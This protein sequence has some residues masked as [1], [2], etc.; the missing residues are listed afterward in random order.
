MTFA[1][2]AIAGGWSQ[3]SHRVRAAA[4]SAIWIGSQVAVHPRLQTAHHLL[5]TGR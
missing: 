3:D 4:S 1:Y 2:T 5:P